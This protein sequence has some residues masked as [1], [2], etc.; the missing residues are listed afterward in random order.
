MFAGHEVSDLSCLPVEGVGVR[1]LGE[2]G[3]GVGVDVHLLGQLEH[4]DV[5]VEA[6]AGWGVA[7]VVEDVGHSDRLLDGGLPSGGK[8]VIPDPHIDLEKNAYFLEEIIIFFWSVY[9]SLCI[10]AVKVF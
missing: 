10:L 7:L 2:A 5:V 9:L 6:A 4:G 3:G 8:V 1:G